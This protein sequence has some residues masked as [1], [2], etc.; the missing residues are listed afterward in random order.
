MRPGRCLGVTLKAEGRSVGALQALQCVVEQA[1]MGSAQIGGQGLFIDGKTVVLAGNADEACVQV[2]DRVVGTMVAKLHLEGFCT[3]GQRHDLVTETDAEGGNGSIDQRARRGNS[4]VTRLGIAGAVGEEDAV[5][6]Q[7]HHV[8]GRSLR[9]HHRHLAAALGQHAQDVEFHAEIEC[10]DVE[11]RIGLSTVA[12]LAFQFRKCQLP[13]CFRPV[14]AL[15]D[16][17]NSGQIKARH[18][19][20]GPGGGGGPINRRLRDHVPSRQRHDAAVLRTVSAQVTRELAGVDIGD[21][22]RAFSYEVVAQSHR[23]A[24]VGGNQRQISNDQPGGEYFARLNVLRV[25]PVISDM[26]VRERNELLA[27]AWVSQDFLITR[28]RRVKNDF[29]DGGA[30]CADG[31]TNINAAIGEG[32]NSQIIV[33]GVSLERQKHWVLRMTTV[34]PKRSQAKTILLQ[35]AQGVFSTW[36]LL[37]EGFGL[38]FAWGEWGWES[39]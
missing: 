35:L 18:R 20:R 6:L 32:Q 36:V 39:S 7:S 23:V 34:E 9:G 4:V 22:D 5:W 13:F 12:G 33:L 21:G 10:N 19:G 29:T 17:D 2:F 28:H 25:D 16:A 30:R 24:K 31:I 15:C 38:R 3:A 1:D 8:C 14:V 37:F 11:L 26:G 27:I